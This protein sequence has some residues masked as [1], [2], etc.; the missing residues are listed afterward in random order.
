MN[1]CI[2]YY[3]SLNFYRLLFYFIGTVPILGL[4]SSILELPLKLCLGIRILFSLWSLV[5]VTNSYL[6]LQFDYTT[7]QH[8]GL[9]HFATDLIPFDSLY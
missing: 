2:I 3:Y 5:L 1:E 4:S 6:F 8:F 7:S 9:E